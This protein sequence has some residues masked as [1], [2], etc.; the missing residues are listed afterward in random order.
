M[1]LGTIETTDETL[2]EQ[3]NMAIFK[4]VMIL[5]IIIAELVSHMELDCLYIQC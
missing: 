5:N 2:S 4:T 1:C 3:A